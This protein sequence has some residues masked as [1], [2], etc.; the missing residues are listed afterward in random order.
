MAR[1]ITTRI[2][3]R[4][5]VGIGQTGGGLGVFAPINVQTPGA[6]A[7]PL[8]GLGQALG[9]FGGIAAERNQVKQAADFEQGKAD[10]TLKKLDPEKV[11]KSQR[12]VDG[13][14]E[15]SMLR[16]YT[17]AQEKVTARAAAELDNSKTLD[18]KTAII[19]GWMREELG[20]FIDDPAGRRVI[21]GRYQQFIEHT[22]GNMLAEEVQ[23]RQTAA[24]DAVTADFT[25]RLSVGG[26]PSFEEMVSPLI[27]IYGDKSKAN[28]MAV[29][30]LAQTKV[31]YAKQ[32][33]DWKALD[34]LVP[35]EI[36]TA[37]GQKLPGPRYTPKLRDM[38][39]R[40]DEAAQRAYDDY[41]K[42]K[43]AAEGY[44]K[45][46]SLDT[47]V[48]VEEITDQTFGRMGITVGDG[49]QY[50]MSYDQARAYKA[51]SLDALRSKKEME[52]EQAQYESLLGKNL[53]WRDII[54]HP[55]GGPENA[56]KAEAG[57]TLQTQR[58]LIGMGIPTNG[59]DFLSSPDA[60][61]AVVN[62]S[63]M[64]DMAYTPLKETMSGINA[65]APG[66]VEARVQVYRMLKAKGIASR[67]VDEEAEAMYETALLA[68]DAGQKGDAL[69]K[70]IRE[71]GDKATAQ[72]VSA[73]MSPKTYKVR[74]QGFELQVP[75]RFY[76]TNGFNS[77]DTLNSAYL[78]MHH[79][80]LTRFYV[81]KNL[82]IDKAQERAASRIMETHI[83]VPLGDT[84]VVLPKDDVPNPQ[85][86]A[87]AFEWLDATLPARAS[88]L[89][90]PDGA[91]LSIDARIGV[92]GRR[93][94][95][96][97]KDRGI[98]VPGPRI[99]IDGLL[100]TYY[101][102][103][104]DKAPGVTGRKAAEAQSVE[105]QAGR[106]ELVKKRNSTTPSGSR[107]IMY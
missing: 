6:A 99:T 66:D 2:D 10:E 12:Y 82:P 60:V 58:T 4:A 51:R 64:H 83:P 107:G 9:M 14:H 16:I 47:L 39:D 22:A 11:A 7:D 21:A 67:Y 81:S 23:A 44:T 43:V 32:G 27:A 102:A 1:P 106:A 89:K 42:P 56:A 92:N 77:R 25:Q 55:E 40:S 38:L 65:A 13:A 35:A 100:K 62:L 93:T 59:A 19:D 46:S 104:P 70:H 74:E 97:I 75:G 18:E 71:N 101:L 49:P 79:E 68:I 31:E 29:S 36:T 90:L 37:D 63:A 33:K 34:A 28:E 30:I 105:S 20:P 69:T 3:R 24:V 8:A 87:E 85:V 54:K 84:Y 80:R 88:E 103:N 73:A 96:Y 50:H 98:E 26:K 95:F 57:F 5:Q 94:E 86:V 61:E 17:D 52:D 15:V 72:A 78:A 76:G 41:T 53:R 45:L 48:G 91:L